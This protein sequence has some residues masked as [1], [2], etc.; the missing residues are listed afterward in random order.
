M[1][2][3]DRN[4]VRRN[5]MNTTTESKKSASTLDVPQPKTR[6]TKKG[7]PAK[8]SRAK[9]PASK[10]KADRANKK[11]EVIALM[12]RAKGATLAEIMAVTK[13][14]AHILQPTK[15]PS[16]TEEQPNPSPF[17]V[18]DEGV[19]LPTR[20]KLIQ[21]LRSQNLGAVHQLKKFLACMPGIFPVRHVT[22]VWNIWHLNHT[23]RR[24]N[25]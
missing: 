11:A 21:I 20:R 13:W 17:R 7:K 23:H 18:G 8:K 2:G 3:R 10:P 16:K 12:K 1:N 19:F 14:Q 15:S 4:P 9:K 24:C 5:A 6:R 22:L 25:R